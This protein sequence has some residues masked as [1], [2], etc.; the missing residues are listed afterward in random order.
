MKYDG[1]N[2]PLRIGWFTTG[3][4]I[5]SYGLF[6]STFNS[7]QSGYLN[8]VIE[9]VFLNREVGLS[10]TTDTFIKS[11]K[12]TGTPLETLSSKTFKK[13]NGN[14]P[15]DKLRE[16]YDRAVIEKLKTYKIDIAVHAGYMLIAPILCNQYMTIN[17]HPD[18]PGETIGMWQQAIWNVIERKKIETGAMIHVST[19][20]VDRG[21][22]LSYCKFP[23]RG[24]DYD[25]LW[26]EISSYETGKLKHKFG[27]ELPLFNKIRKDGLS[28]E[29]SL[30]NET[31]FSIQTGEIS[32]G[33][34]KKSLDLTDRVNHHL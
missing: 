15:W 17:L 31:L 23:V 14:L 24:K 13:H 1:G 33:N 4:G 10:E 30:L 28:R 16:N 6:H 2:S 22:V 25:H 20:K 34:V 5:G 29:T 8:G 26:D 12:K 18:L 9:F 32:L 27:E 21:P 11:I 3:R 19:D 7:I